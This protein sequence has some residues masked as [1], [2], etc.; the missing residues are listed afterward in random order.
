MI[1]VTD[2]H[3]LLWFLSDD[4]KLS[5]K[6]KEIFLEAEK[7]ESTLVIPSIVLAE[8]MYVFEKQDAGNNFR[9]LLENIKIAENYEIYPLD[10]E[11]LEKAFDI[12]TI[13]ELHDRI[14]VASAQ[15]LDC[16]IITKDEQI[17][18]SKEA[19]CIW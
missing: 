15:L 14:I 10:I 6:A 19:K 5:R 17:T 18:N 4:P 2:T 1:Y 3:P 8:L 7:G 13:K 9:I 12:K 11:T 16:E